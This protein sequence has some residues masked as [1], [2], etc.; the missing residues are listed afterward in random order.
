MTD[1]ETTAFYGMFDSGD[2]V[3]KEPFSV[4]FEATTDP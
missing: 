4:L 3:I 2:I 1:R